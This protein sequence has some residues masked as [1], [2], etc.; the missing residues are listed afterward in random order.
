MTDDT[1]A[2][3]ASTGERTTTETDA[4]ADWPPTDDGLVALADRLR[5]RTHALE[6]TDPAADLADLDPLV[7]RLRDARVVG[8]GEA[9]HGTREFF[10]LKHRLLRLLVERLDYRLFA[11]EANFAETL[12]IDEYVVHGRGDPRDALDGIYFWTW[13]TEEVLALVEWLREF[14]DG[15]PVEDRVRFYGVDAQFTA[16]PA[17]ALLDFFDGR[18]AEW[19][20]EHRDTLSMLADEGLKADD[21]DEPADERV[22]D[23]EA[24]VDALGTWFDERS[25]DAVALHRRHLRTLDQAVGVNAAEHDDD[26]A[27][28]ATRRDRAMADNVAWMLDHEPHDRVAVWAHDGHLQ[29]GPRRM[30]WGEA[31]SMGSHLADRHGDD[32]YAVGFDFGGGEFQAMVETDDGHELAVCSLDPPPADAATRLFAAV[33][34]SCLFLDFD[35]ATDDERLAAWFDDERSVRSLGAVYDADGEPDSANASYRLPEYFDGLVY[36]AETARAR[37]IERD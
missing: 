30:Q 36:V 8:L 20:D 9:T 16:G 6:T 15:R 19:P 12:A 33:G 27:T 13:D 22:A 29:R 32:Y 3:D 2:T 23:A 24:A 10:R 25:D 7:E 17:G 4:D 34:E 18:D 11:L 1:T 14:N 26:V 37:P 21:P 28:M 31:P 35:G 5:E